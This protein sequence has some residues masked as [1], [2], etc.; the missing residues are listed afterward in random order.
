MSHTAATS[1]AD[2]VDWIAD[3]IPPYIERLSSGDP[4]DAAACAF[5]TV[6]GRWPAERVGAV[7]PSREADLEDALCCFDVGLMAD[8]IT[9]AGF[10]P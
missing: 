1:R 4:W 7:T 10:E 5:K 3:G 2:L 8:A 6:L 9:A